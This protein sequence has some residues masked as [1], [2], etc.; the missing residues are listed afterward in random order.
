MNGI[1]ALLILLSLVGG[2]VAAF[3]DPPPS[4][5][6]A[7]H[8][9][10]ALPA[11]YSHF[12]DVNP[13]APRGGSL[14]L[15]VLGSYDSLN[16]LIV[17]GVPA[18]GMREHVYESLMI[19]GP[20]EPFTLYGLIAEGVEVPPDRSS[21][22]FHLRPQARFSDGRRIRPADVIFSWELL[23][24]RGRPNTRTYYSKVVGASQVG[25]N[26]VRFDFGAEGD[27]EMPLIMGLMPILPEHATDPETFERTTLDPPIGSGPYRV[28]QVAAGTRIVYERDPDYWA[29]DLPFN[30]GRNNFDRIVYDYFRD[31]TALFEAFN[32]GLVDLVVDEDPTRWAQGYGRESAGGIVR[33]TLTLGTPRPLSALVFNTRRAPFDDIRVR[34]ALIALFDAQWINKTLYADLFGRTEGYFDGSELSAS[35]RPADEIEKALLG[36]RLGTLAPELIDGTFRQ[37]ASDGGGR[38][39]Q[40]QRQAT[41]LLAAAGYSIRDGLM[42][43]GSGRPLSFEILV[44]TR[45]QERLALTYAGMLKRAGIAA[46][47]RSVDA[48]QFEQ[49]RQ[50]Y[51]FDV[52]P[53]VWTQSLSPG[54]EQAFYWSSEAAGTEGTRN[55]PGIRDED[56]DRV[57]AAIAAARERRPFVAAVRALDRL[58]IGGHY[59]IPLYHIPG[60][61]IARWTR[62]ERPEMIPLNGLTIDLLWHR[63]VAR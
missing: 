44:A 16:P 62:I 42:R 57:I 17:R 43:E 13:H 1:P 31:E 29:R 41:G 14:T 48:V 34:Q 22:I 56:V 11:G 45:E 24:S 51:D 60:Q 37:P 49:R 63:E 47:V 27:R 28:A 39:R 25:E 7:M 55:Y 23:R 15:P 19:R 2:P 50:T 30:V 12:P 26:G 58:L 10:P 52:L 59:L 32:K 53:N 3:A 33:E 21:I 9:E 46:R 38:N 35:G 20:D 36:D 18:K 54:N 5:G 8:G 40:G 61:W 6:I 4:H